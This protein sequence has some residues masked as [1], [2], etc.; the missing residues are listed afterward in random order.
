MFSML[1]RTARLSSVCV[2]VVSRLR[3]IPVLRG[4]VVNFYLPER[5]S[6]PSTSHPSLPFPLLLPFLP[7]LPFPLPNPPSLSHPSTIFPPSVVPPSSFNPP[8]SYP[9]L[10]SF[11][12]SS[13][14]SSVVT[15][16]HWP[17]SVGFG[18]VWRKK[19]WFQLGGRFWECCGQWT[20]SGVFKA[21]DFH[22]NTGRRLLIDV[23]LRGRYHQTT[24]SHERQR[25]M[26]T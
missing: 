7:S 15:V 5:S 17:R 9:P 26:I 14:P 25:V 19:S 2:H 6:S 11:P 21:G 20:L 1:S 12:N 4:V 16:S 18:S 3:P 10:P 13:I 23:T 24:H 22:H 8:S